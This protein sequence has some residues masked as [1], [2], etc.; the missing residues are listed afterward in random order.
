MPSG[1][2]NTST[3]IALLC[4]FSCVA[5]EPE[6]ATWQGEN[7]L[8]ENSLS[9]SA[10]RGTH[11]WVD[12]FPKFI[13][14]QLDLADIP[15]LNYR[16]LESQYL[17]CHE[18]VE[19]CTTP[20]GVATSSA[21]FLLHELV[22]AAMI[23]LNQPYQPFFGEGLAVALD[24][25][26]GNNLGP[27]Y[28]GRPNGEDMFT[29]PRPWMTSEADGLHYYVAGSFVSFLLARHGP[30]N[31]LEFTDR[32]GSSRDMKVIEAVFREIYARELNDEAEAF[33]VGPPCPETAVGPIL[34]DCTAM[35][36]PWEGRLH[37]DGVMD[38]LE[39]DIA[40]GYS[41]EQ[42]WSSIRSVTFMV[43][44]TAEWTADFSLRVEG[45]TPL[46]VQIGP[47]FGCPWRRREYAASGSETIDM[48]L[49]GGL[50]YARILGS[51]DEVTDYVVDLDIKS[52][53]Y[54]T[55]P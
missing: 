53:P 44:G 39:D 22:H 54:P 51:S 26:N 49:A 35:E 32:L 3:I 33:M 7:V 43:P 34:Y 27:T 47:C 4:C 37:L 25:L 20:S 46:R 10:C 9:L 14:E 40:G 31:F 13:T 41:D 17:N 55:P 11:R 48:A 24:P 38:C 16:W 42:T 50:H 1:S 28:V 2:K 15:E 36:V 18:D 19:G 12:G 21:P 52:V 45:D 30:V 8:Y 6:L 23:R 5:E 29:D